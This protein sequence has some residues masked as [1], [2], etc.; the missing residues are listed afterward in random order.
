MLGHFCS[1]W[2]GTTCLFPLVLLVLP[3]DLAD[4]LEVRV[5]CLLPFDFPVAA[6]STIPSFVHRDLPGP[7]MPG[8][9]AAVERRRGELNWADCSELAAVAEQGAAQ[10][11]A[12]R[13]AL[14]QWLR[15]RPAGEPVLPMAHSGG[16]VEVELRLDRRLPGASHANGTW[17]SMPLTLMPCPARNK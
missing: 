17:Y 10:L 15:A 7:G 4:L 1:A 11:A 2:S 8:G 3:A 5:H 9:A 14:L 13:I 12:A 16:K 6:R